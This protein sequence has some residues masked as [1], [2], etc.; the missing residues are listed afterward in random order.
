MYVRRPRGCGPGALSSRLRMVS[1][2]FSAPA[3][4]VS[5]NDEDRSLA[6]SLTSAEGLRRRRG[7]AL[8]VVLG[9][10]LGHLGSFALRACLRVTFSLWR[11]WKRGSFDLWRGIPHRPLQIGHMA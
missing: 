8:A 4:V 9:E 5:L 10:L 6:L 7:V 1:P 11:K 3:R 2:F